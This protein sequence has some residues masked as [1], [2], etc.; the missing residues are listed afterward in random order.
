MGDIA[1][2]V[3][4]IVEQIKKDRSLSARA[5]MPGNRNN[6][7]A[8]G[9]E[10][11]SLP[12]ASKRPAAS[13]S[14]TRK[15]YGECPACGKGQII[16]GSRGYGCNRFREGCNYVVWKEFYGKKLS[17]AAIDLLIKGK[18]TR[19]IKGFVLSDGRVVSGRL[20]MKEDRSGIDLVEIKE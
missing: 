16:E 7:G 2:F 17:Q 13:P 12:A 5:A 10:R 11:A 1:T 14:L 19:L 3:S 9:Q 6:D 4:K 18:K 15:T 20:G 8:V